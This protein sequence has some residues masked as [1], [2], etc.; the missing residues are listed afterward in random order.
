MARR[1]HIPSYGH[2][3]ASGQAR[4]I[5]DGKHIYLGAHGSEKSLKTYSKLI[6]GLLYDTSPIAPSADAS[7]SLNLTV[8]ELLLRYWRFAESHYKGVWFL[9]FNEDYTE[10]T[11]ILNFLYNP[12]HNIQPGKRTD[13][14]RSSPL[15]VEAK[16]EPQK[17]DFGK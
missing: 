6:A 5:I 2:H 3:K 15:R 9:F 16:T 8:K 17:D 12:K 7:T 11:K 13:P 1:T 4:I 14:P 10:Y